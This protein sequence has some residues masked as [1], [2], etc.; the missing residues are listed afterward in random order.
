ME[1]NWLK[2]GMKKQVEPTIRTHAKKYMNTYNPPNYETRQALAKRIGSL[3]HEEK[4]DEITKWAQ[5]KVKLFKSDFEAAKQQYRVPKKKKPFFTGAYDL[6]KKVYPYTPT[7][8]AQSEVKFL[9]GLPAAAKKSGATKIPKYLWDRFAQPYAE[10]I[11]S[12]VV[13]PL[14]QD[15]SS[16]TWK[17]MPE[18]TPA[19]KL[20]KE[21]ARRRDEFEGRS[22]LMDSLIAPTF[23]GTFSGLGSGSVFHAKEGL[24]LKAQAKFTE[25]NKI[26]YEQRTP[27]QEKQW[28][29]HKAYLDQYS[30]HYG[31]KNVMAY[32]D[33]TAE[34]WATKKIEEGLDPVE[35]GK[36]KELFKS[37]MTKQWETAWFVGDWIGTILTMGKI[38]KIVGAIG[39][40]LSKLHI[41]EKVGYTWLKNLNF[42]SNT[43]KILN[44][45]PELQKLSNAVG[46]SYRDLTHTSKAII[47]LEREIAAYGEKEVPKRLGIE[48]SNLY[49]RQKVLQETLDSGKLAY[50]ATSDVIKRLKMKAMGQHM[51]QESVT[52]FTSGAMMSALQGETDENGNWHPS[53]PQDILTAGAT[54]AALGAGVT[55][56]THGINLIRYKGAQRL[57]MDPEAALKVNK[58]R[59]PLTMFAPESQEGAIAIATQKGLTQLSAQ[60]IGESLRAYRQIPKRL[61]LE[62]TAEIPYSSDEL[63][64]MRR[65]MNGEFVLDYKADTMNRYVD[66]PQMTKRSQMDRDMLEAFR[67]MLK[68]RGWKDA[69]A[70]EERALESNTRLGSMKDATNEMIELMSEFDRIPQSEVQVYTDSYNR[71]FVNNGRSRGTESFQNALRVVLGLPRAVPIIREIRATQTARAIA[72]KRIKEFFGDKYAEM[73]EHKQRSDVPIIAIEKLPEGETGG[74]VKEWNHDGDYD[75]SHMSKYK[76]QKYNVP[77]PEPEPVEVEPPKVSPPSGRTIESSKFDKADYDFWIGEAKVATEEIPNVDT[78]YSL[79]DYKGTPKDFLTSKLKSG[80]DPVL[81]AKVAQFTADDIAATVDASKYD[82]VVAVPGYYP[83]AVAKAVADKLGLKYEPETIKKGK[84]FDQ[85]MSTDKQREKQVAN[86]FKLTKPPAGTRVLLID[87]MMATGSTMSEVARVLKAE[88]GAQSVEGVTVFRTIRKGN[89]RDLLSTIPKADEGEP[90][91]PGLEKQREKIHRKRLTEDKVELVDKTEE[92]PVKPATPA[93]KT[94]KPAT[95]KQQQKVHD[96]A[97]EVVKR[98]GKT[99]E[100]VLAE[101]SKFIGKDGEEVHFKDATQ[102]ANR[103][104]VGRTINK[105]ENQLK[106][107]RLTREGFIVAL[108]EAMP[109]LDASKFQSAIEM[110]DAL[111]K[112]WGKANNVD[113]ARYYET[114]FAGIENGLDMEGMIASTTF[115]ANGASLWR[116]GEQADIESFVHESAHFI[117]RNILTAD[118]TAALEKALGKAYGEPEFKF[119][120]NPET[121]R[122]MEERFT[123]AVLDYLRNP[124]EW[125]AT[126]YEPY[127]KKMASW[128]A[129]INQYIEGNP[130]F[131]RSD[132][133]TAELRTTFERVFGKKA[134]EKMKAVPAAETPVN[135]AYKTER[136]PIT[137][138]EMTLFQKARKH[139]PLK[140]GEYFSMR[141]G[142]YNPIT[143]YRVGEDTMESLDDTIAA[144]YEEFGDKYNIKVMK[145]YTRAEY[146]AMLAKDPFETWAATM[147]EMRKEVLYY[148]ML[149]NFKNTP[150]FQYD[151]TAPINWKRLKGSQW[152]ELDGMAVDPRLERQLRDMTPAAFDKAGEEAK[153]LAT[154]LESY[155]LLGRTH[156]RTV[157]TLL[158]PATHNRNFMGNTLFDFCAGIHPTETLMETEQSRTAMSDLIWRNGYMKGTSTINPILRKEQELGIINAQKFLSDTQGWGDEIE[159]LKHLGTAGT[160]SQYLKGVYNNLSDSKVGRLYQAE[161]L[162]Y[163]TRAFLVA[164]KPIEQGGMG[165]TDEAAAIFVMNHYPDYSRVPTWMAGNRIGSWKNMPVVGAPFVSFQ[166]ETARILMNSMMERPAR[167]VM[168]FQI[169]VMMQHYSQI[170]MGL[171]NE[172][173]DRLKQAGYGYMPDTVGTPWLT[174]ALFGKDPETDEIYAINLSYILPNYEM[175]QNVMKVYDWMKA[176]MHDDDE[177]R[178]QNMLLHQSENDF[179]RYV[180]AQ[181][182]TTLYLQAGLNVNPFTRKPETQ[183]TDVPDNLLGWIDPTGKLSGETPSQ[184]AR[185]RYH[186]PLLRTLTPPWFELPMPAD[187]SGDRDLAGYGAKKMSDAGIYSLT[188]DTRKRDISYTTSTEVFRDP[189]TTFA[190]VFLGI[191]IRHQSMAERSKFKIAD[192]KQQLNEVKGDIKHAKDK[193]EQYQKGNAGY[194]AMEFTKESVRLEGIK[195]VIEKQL[196]IWQDALN[197]YEDTTGTPLGYKPGIYKPVKF[198]P[199]EFK[200][201]ANQ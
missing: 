133:V 198:T 67:Q 110:H 108:K 43:A 36:R 9:A 124:K 80:S 17:S 157:M 180:F 83:E 125:K 138:D 132:A 121:T 20:D 101:A 79:H 183:A 129:E 64:Q 106:E 93:A 150:M 153:G 200:P 176:G 147:Y 48:L 78:V 185:E 188:G 148:K 60:E 160:F 45:E 99:R 170:Q 23:F 131:N 38:S 72:E 126:E 161:D 189:L 55:A 61:T 137:P 2:R 86:A 66:N 49:G 33:E 140:S 85:R 152:G 172:E 44:S 63:A 142:R 122:A 32:I 8:I 71:F 68:R 109:E 120:E 51:A 74:L 90:L 151:D 4:V 98:T 167:T 104:W 165:L 191:S 134:I 136:P 19:E 3:S 187:T 163:K 194:T 12:H 158:N 197:G 76:R 7:G 181:P 173:A 84:K 114:F 18:G 50:K 21:M 105:L 69:A 5:G 14:K 103:S 82:V 39:E 201:D 40:P 58:K 144:M 77:T 143:K 178:I 117:R 115:N 113:P 96:L 168:A 94:Y 128:L 164:T 10:N 169:P 192:L 73:F 81:T 130:S 154:E 107:P 22:E 95:T 127:I 35:V 54:W 145:P 190:D 26:P 13:D 16:G 111:A 100:E 6:L 135:Q 199:K 57:A 123:D 171:S 184:Y 28:S 155:F 31:Q 116:M 30:L 88:G 47:E 118:E 141:Q 25:L 119:G 177:M 11:Y 52:A 59:T 87:D 41:A 182:E 15:L 37:R 91:A 42:L 65:Y 146:D 89:A 196:V 112:A 174:P 75:V 149:R 53:T 166:Y 195:D 186:E 162:F 175:Y 27:E 24:Y 156:F 159:G 139:S 179:N 34:K 193:R 70:I 1:S 62:G 29:E 102:G 56:I 92:A 97:D 46:V